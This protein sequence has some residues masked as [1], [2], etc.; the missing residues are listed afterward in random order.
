M[1]VSEVDLITFVPNT[2]TVNEDRQYFLNKERTIFTKVDSNLER[3]SNEANLLKGIDHPYIQKYVDSRVEND[4]HYLETEYFAGK[5]LEECRES[6]KH[7]H[8][9]VIQTQLLEVLAFM[10]LYQIKHN[11]IN[12]SNILFNGKHILIIDWETATT[13]NPLDDLF[14]EHDHQGILNTLRML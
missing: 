14:G 6:L 5:S 1:A 4:H 12:V 11:D 13:G 10:S 9:I 8:K 7:E 2:Q 3:G